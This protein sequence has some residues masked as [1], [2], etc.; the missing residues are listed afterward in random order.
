MQSSVSTYEDLTKHY[1][2]AIDALCEIARSYFAL[3]RSN[4]AQHLLRTSLHLLEASEVKPQHRLKLLLLYGQVLVV[5]HLLTR[6]DA[7]LLFST[8][9]QAKQLADS[10][11]LLGMKPKW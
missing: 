6:G 3:G 8:I 7:D 11:K 1:T 5:D 2:I 10:A 4:D 9:L